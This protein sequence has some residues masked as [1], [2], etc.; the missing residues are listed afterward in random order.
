VKHHSEFR[1]LERSDS[2]HQYG[3]PDV[4]SAALP[5]AKLESFQPRKEELS[6]SVVD[7]TL[8]VVTIG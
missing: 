8:G 6:I 1:T 4:G 3:V 2:E 7:K 5:A